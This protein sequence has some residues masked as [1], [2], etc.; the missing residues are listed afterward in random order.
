LDDTVGGFRTVEGCGRGPLENFDVLDGLR[1]E[2]VEARR[3]SVTRSSTSIVNPNPIN[4]NNGLVT[5]G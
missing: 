3:S 4:V 5:L 2:I 1:I